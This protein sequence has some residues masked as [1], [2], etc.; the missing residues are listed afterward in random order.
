M[1]FSVPTIRS[2]SAALMVKQCLCWRVSL[3]DL[4]S[5]IHPRHR[6]SPNPDLE[7]DLKLKNRGLSADLPISNSDTYHCSDEGMPLVML[8]LRS[9]TVLFETLVGVPLLLER[10]R[11]HQ[12]GEVAR[13]YLGLNNFRR[14]EY[15]RRPL[16]YLTYCPGF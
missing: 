1:T 16:V 11:G 7:F 9:V 4:L 15:Q 10:V 5:C 6:N 14:L 13:V 2:V 8:Y 3:V 12:N